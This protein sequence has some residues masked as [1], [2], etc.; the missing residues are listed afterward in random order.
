M[1]LQ[2]VGSDECLSTARVGAHMR[3]LGNMTGESE[4]LH[5]HTILYYDV[6]RDAS[7]YAANTIYDSTLLAIL[8]ETVRYLS[9]VRRAT[10]LF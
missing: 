1:S 7:K 8:I 4:Q 9:S 5:Y 3:T 10:V 2:V 6:P